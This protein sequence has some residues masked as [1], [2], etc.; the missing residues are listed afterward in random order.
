MIKAFR[1]NRLAKPGF[2]IFFVA[3]AFGSTIQSAQAADTKLTMGTGGKG[4]YYFHIGD[5]LCESFAQGTNGYKC[6]AVATDGPR[7]NL[8]KLRRGKFDIVVARSDWAKRALD[9]SGAFEGKGADTSL[10]SLF[11]IHSE[12]LTIIARK[13]AGIGTF[14][15]LNGKRVRLGSS[16]T[17]LFRQSPQAANWG[18]SGFKTLKFRDLSQQ[19]A[20]LCAGEIDAIASVVGYPSGWVQKTAKT[21]PIQLVTVP[22]GQV[23][24]SGELAKATIPASTYTGVTSP[25]N[26]LGYKATILSSAE[27]SEDDVYAFVKSTFEN[28]AELGRQHPALSGLHPSGM[29]RDGL[30]APL[31]PGAARY[32]RE[33]GWIK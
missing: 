10:R 1:L 2:F 18:T 29:I 32:Y 17:Q 27:V 31:H 9:G 4:G 28:L 15:D 3:A 24:G 8:P 30:P 5:L 14:G 33:Q 6:R 11:S 25:T 23:S 22:S 12:P 7:E 26:T 21:C 13:G 19:S 16:A 20:A